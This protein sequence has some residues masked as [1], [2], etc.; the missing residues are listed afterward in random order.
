MFFNNGWS[1]ANVYMD[2]F[3][4]DEKIISINCTAEKSLDPVPYLI[5]LHAISRCDSVPIMYDIG[6]ATA[7]KAGKTSKFFHLGNSEADLRD[8]ITEG[9]LFVAKGY[10]LQSICSYNKR[11]PIWLAKTNRSE[12]FAKP[13][14][15]KSLP[16]TDDALALNIMRS[17]Y[18]ALMWRNCLS[19]KPRHW[20]LANLAGN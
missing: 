5:T 1:V 20:I 3:T 8:V 19:G 2:S 14:A 7:L 6:K 15:F 16:P 11:Q 12:L 4:K 18:V 13:P 17:Y 10:G 9:N